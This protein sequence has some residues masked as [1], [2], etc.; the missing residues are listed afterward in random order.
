MTTLPR[1]TLA[2][3]LRRALFLSAVSLLHA[4]EPMP[5]SPPPLARQTA[6]RF[7][8]V[9]P[10]QHL[11]RQPLNDAVSARAWTNYLDVLDPDHTV[12]LDSDINRLRMYATALDDEVKTGDL[13]F[14]YEAIRIYRR[15]FT[16]R[17]AF[18]KQTAGSGFDFGKD[19]TYTIPPDRTWPKSQDEWDTLWHR[20]VK[21]EVLCRLVA[22][23]ARPRDASA[24]TRANES[25]LAAYDEQLSNPPARPDSEWILAAFLN[26]VARAYD[27]DSVY[28]PPDEEAGRDDAPAEKT[29]WS[30]RRLRTAKGNDAPFGVIRPS[31]FYRGAGGSASR[32]ISRVLAHMRRERVTGVLLD[33]RGNA[34][35]CQPE[36][37][38]VT[39]LF[40]ARG[41]VVLT[42]RADGRVETHADTDSRT[43][44][45]GPL[46]ILVDRMTAS[47]AE[48]LSGTLQDYGR[49][50]VV[51]DSRTYGK[52]RCQTFHPLGDG[53]ELGT[54][55]ITTMANY[56]VSGRSC[57]EYGI[58]SDIVMPSVYDVCFDA[59]QTV[60][61]VEP[62]VKAAAFTPVGDLAP[63]IPRL[64]EASEKRRSGDPRHTARA[65]RLATVARVVRT[66]EIPLQWEK[67]LA[68]VRTCRKLG[69]AHGLLGGK[70]SPASL[71]SDPFPDLV[72]EEAL[73]VLRDLA[74]TKDGRQN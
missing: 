47:A 65:E 59:R 60:D 18:V 61:S 16:D 26:A 55:C 8:D 24:L 58:S 6:R 9:L 35:G 50:I 15:R 45:K 21:H 64:R 53:A 38:A 46:V 54:A 71:P 74:E 27:L 62:P 36:T 13:T 40:I 25:L 2:E 51:G 7:A 43:A 1:T 4:T 37:V 57:Q 63:L 5:V 48:V 12:F 68:L 39:G 14:A 67:R 22:A 29:T 23:E 70:L 34:G 52:G 66:R 17:V 19:E 42:R 3:F 28:L 30:I 11:S 41:P 31:S 72:L 73:A 44:H 49:A 69:D 56:C 20:K 32:D 10:A 33:L